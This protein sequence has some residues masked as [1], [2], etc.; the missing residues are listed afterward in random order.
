MSRQIV[1]KFEVLGSPHSGKWRAVDTLGP[2]G[3]SP[4]A[5]VGMCKHAIIVLLLFRLA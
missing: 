1:R 2:L 5:G 3:A 4:V